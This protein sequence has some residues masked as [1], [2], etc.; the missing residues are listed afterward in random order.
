VAIGAT[1]LGEEGGEDVD[2]A[3][4]VSSAA[5]FLMREIDSWLEL[6]GAAE[7]GARTCAG[8]RS[9]R[10]ASCARSTSAATCWFGSTAR[11]TPERRALASAG[12]AVVARP[13]DRDAAAVKLPR[14]TALD[15]SDTFVFE[16]AAEP[17]EWA[18]SGAFV[19]ADRDPAALEGKA[20]AAFRSGLARRGE[21]RLVDA[22]GGRRGDRRG[23]RRGGRGAR[24][25]SARAARRAEPRGGARGGARGGRVRAIPLR[26]FRGNADRRAAHG[27][28]RRRARALPHAGAARGQRAGRPALGAGVPL[29]ARATPRTS[30]SSASTSATS[31]GGGRE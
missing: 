4:L 8:S 31:R 21:L 16:R 9:A 3:T 14:T 24:R 26:A 29:R 25:P 22:R 20:R 7:R 5:K 1:A 23:A 2:A 28:G 6:G 13:D 17:G 15:A 19:F 12:G 30:P 10:R 18:V 11:A 27:R